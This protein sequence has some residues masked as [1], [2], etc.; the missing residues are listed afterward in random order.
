M[1]DPVYFPSP[2]DI[3]AKDRL[4]L[5]VE[6]RF[7]CTSD[8]RLLFSLGELQSYQELFSSCFLVARGDAESI[9]AIDLCRDI[10]AELG[11]QSRTL[12]S[13]LYLEN[14][15]DMALAGAAHHILDWYRTHQYC[16][17]CGSRNELHESE[18][19]MRCPRCESLSFPR[20][21]PCA[22]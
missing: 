7:L 17:A 19:V 2:A 1:T 8:D 21:N 14:Q 10:S 16:G 13:L 4:I 12:R 11:A 5:H 18:R 6:G 15:D 3:T 20:I 9:L 22:I